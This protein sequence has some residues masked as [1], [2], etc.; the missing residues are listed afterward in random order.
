MNNAW[1]VS[2]VVLLFFLGTLAPVQSEAA[3]AKKRCIKLNCNQQKKLCATAFK[4]QLGTAKAGCGDLSGKERKT[5][6]K[7]AKRTFNQN[8]K[9]CKSAFK[10]CKSCCKRETIGCGVRVFGDG[11]CDGTQVGASEQCDGTDDD[12]CPGQCQADCTCAGG[13]T[14]VALGL[15]S[16]VDRKPIAGVAVT[17]AS[18][19]STSTDENGY[20]S[21]YGLATSGEEIA[22]FRKSGFATTVKALPV[23]EAG[24]AT[25]FSVIMAAAA[26]TVTIN[27]DT[28]STQRSGD[29]AVSITAGSL[30]DGSGNPVIGDVELTATFIDP[31]TDAVEAFPGSFDDAR[32]ESGASVT[33][34]SFGFAMYEL[35]K[36]GQEVDLAAG[37]TAGIEY[38]L[39][40]NAQGRF[41]AG[42]TIP[43]WEFDQNTAS[44]IERGQGEIR[45]ASDGS[46]R[47]AWFATVGHFSSW[48]CDAPIGEKNC[49][50]GRV[51]VDGSPVNG[52][53]IVAIGITYNGT[54]TVQT[55]TDGTFCVEVKRGSTVNVEVRVNGV[56]RALANREIT[57]ADAA[58]SCGTGG[59]TDV[60]DIGITWDSCV[61]GRVTEK[62]G[63]PVAGAT[64]Y[65]APGEVVTTGSDGSFCARAPGNSTV[66]V[67][68]GGHL[69]SGVTAPPSA[70][71]GAANCA[72]ADLALSL[73][74]AGD[75]VGSLQATKDVV[76]L[77][78]TLPGVQDPFELFDLSGRFL[79]FDSDREQAGTSTLEG[80]SVEQFG[81]CTV[82]TITR[83]FSLDDPVPQMPSI[84]IGALDPGS[85]GR[86]SNGS[87]TLDLLPGEPSAESP[88]ATGIFSPPA[89]IEADLLKL[90]FNAGQTVSFSFPGGAD[91]GAF[92]ATVN[93]PPD[94]N[95]TSP[96]LS[97]P[98]LR[99][100]V[101]NPLNVTWVAYEPSGVV[102][103]W[104]GGSEVSI[105]PTST[106]VT[107]A[108]IQCEV[109]DTG[110]GTIPADLMSRLPVNANG[111]F[112]MLHRSRLT[113]VEV[114][115][116]RVAG[117]GV[118]EVLG[119]TSVSR[120]FYKTP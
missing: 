23:S 66:Y 21:F 14:G 25:P 68:T 115:L 112:V 33:L 86:A 44:W 99:V 72:A 105:G 106:V 109:P 1:K 22:T 50:V 75:V 70:S 81:D 48:N 16:G 102:W 40:G 71:C 107:F 84:E 7:V 30:A 108:L 54:S 10:V 111:Y 85:P 92:D 95:V 74:E 63:T 98:N 69:S 77:G 100:D 45:E 57:V 46:G 91:I 5:C 20:Y 94:L 41:R 65:A 79:V 9:K 78:M 60:G 61:M 42:D 13:G 3:P 18:G 73:P 83:T 8:N 11:V 39:P 56:T 37:K 24:S 110:S 34:E 103:L 88:H 26:E 116:R 27:A 64:V 43:L 80:Y 62:D 31:S 87:V 53:E 35:T 90:G 52:A 32:S 104:V 97:D 2:F 59:C 117:R 82:T 114:P 4:N 67:F 113:D 118:V 12:A 15:I 55:G 51:T 93:V 38:V 47:L 76:H 58:A 36:D 29:S 119:M 101:N 89:E 96:D 17:L 6:K 19:R 28:S 49:V 120:F